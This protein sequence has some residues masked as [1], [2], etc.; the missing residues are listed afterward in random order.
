MSYGKTK[1]KL[2]VEGIGRIYEAFAY[3]GESLKLLKNIDAKP[4][5]LRDLA[6]AR[7]EDKR[8]SDFCSYYSYVKEG[9]IYTP[10]NVFFVSDSPFL[11]NP[12]KAS[13][14]YNGES[15][16]AKKLRINAKKYLEQAEQDEIKE[17]QNRKVLIS[18]VGKHRDINNIP[19]YYIPTNRF[20]DDELT[21]WAFKD[22]AE[23]YGEFLKDAGIDEISVVFDSP[24]QK[25][26]ARQLLLHGC[27]S[28]RSGLYCGLNGIGPKR[29][30]FGVKE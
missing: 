17:P 20:N 11:S 6:Y 9:I 8:I 29:N 12:K 24:R 23:E 25:P 30:M 10:K 3:L 1:F 19:F 7:I 22:K 26:F 13:Q 4:I 2:K 14:I 5:S 18:E 15:Y 21:L 28:G 16:E 27:G